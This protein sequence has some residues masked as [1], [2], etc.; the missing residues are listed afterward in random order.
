MSLLEME[1]MTWEEID[2]LDRQKTIVFLPLSP[3]E[4][5]GPHLPLGT[6][7]YA[8][9]DIARLSFPLLEQSGL[10]LNCLLYPGLALGCA[11][12]TGDFPGTVSLRGSTLV[13]VIYDIGASFANHGFQYF[14]IINHHYDIYHMKAISVAMDKIH[15]KY[16]M[17]L[18]EPLGTSFFSAKPET[19]TLIPGEKDF[20]LDREAHAEYE[21]T[22]FMLYQH[23]ELL[24][25]S[26]RNLPPVYINLAKQYIL[27]RWTL[28][29]MG[30]RQGYVGTPARATPEYGKSY[31]ETQAR[32]V[33]DGALKLYR[34]EELPQ[35]S[36]KL[37]LAM[38]LLKLG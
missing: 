21:E 33:A 15:K 17:A 19:I 32:I 25:E 7:F 3:V 24:K 13:K 11:S 2:A 38:K 37:R 35:I 22:S 9:M 26:W 16:H 34:G 4:E 31:L 14:I 1:K 28:R 5:H 12:I 6:D 36:L 18:Y 29:K 27:G 10:R 30:A 8:V 20:N 23:P